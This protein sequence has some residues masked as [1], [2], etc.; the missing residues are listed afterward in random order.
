MRGVCM[1]GSVPACGRIPVATIATFVLAGTLSLAATNSPTVL[2]TG[3]RG[4]RMLS[5]APYAAAVLP[6]SGV[7]LEVLVAGLNASRLH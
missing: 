3:S 5:H 6:R 2:V 7:R 1:W 4:E